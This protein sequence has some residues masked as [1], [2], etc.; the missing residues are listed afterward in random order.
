M[1]SG[2][3]SLIMSEAVY[4]AIRETVFAT[5]DG[6]ETGVTLFGCRDDGQSVALFAAG[7]GPRALHAPAFHE[8]DIAFLN[9]GFDLLRQSFPRLE[10][11]GS[12]HVH[13]FGMP[14]LSGHDRR[15]IAAV[16]AG[17][18]APVAPDFIAG[19]I[20][21][22][23]S[24]MLLYPYRV[25]RS[26]PQPR[27]IPLLVVPPQSDLVRQALGRAAQPEETDPDSAVAGRPG[28]ASQPSS[29]RVAAAGVMSRMMLALRRWRE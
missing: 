26:D 12:L 3:S 7:P 4:A 6:L 11:I 14:W 15:T 23:R 13:P 5:P 21:R 2:N 20:Q 16:L 1:T 25:A 28:A 10:W 29:R 27:L 18:D 17:A 9:R 24:N 8:P 19:I 22:Q